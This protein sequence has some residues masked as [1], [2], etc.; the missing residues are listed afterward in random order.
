M[1]HVKFSTSDRFTVPD[2]LTFVSTGGVKREILKRIRR[3]AY[4]RSLAATAVVLMNVSLWTP[5]ADR[6]ESRQLGE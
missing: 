4:V 2:N 3:S 5:K 1:H 6:I